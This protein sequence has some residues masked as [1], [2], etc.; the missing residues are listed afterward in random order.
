[1]ENFA[2]NIAC[3]A[4]QIIAMHMWYRNKNKQNIFSYIQ[5]SVINSQN[6][7]VIIFF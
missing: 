4:L 1:M 7:F 5:D 3:F 6:G 2:S